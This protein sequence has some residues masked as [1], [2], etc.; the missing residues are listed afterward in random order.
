MLEQIV[1]FYQTDLERLADIWLK[2]GAKCFGL[3]ASDQPIIQWTKESKESSENTGSTNRLSFPINFM[4]RPLGEIFV[5]GISGDWV[6][7]LLES[8]GIYVLR[9]IDQER[10][11]ESLAQE[12]VNNQDQL[13]AVYDLLHS[14]RNMVSVTEIVEGIV[15]ATGQIFEVSTAFIQVTLPG[16]SQFVSAH[17]QPIEEIVSN[18]LIERT[19]SENDYWLFSS[20]VVED[21]ILSKYI[22]TAVTIPLNIQGES[23][24]VLGLID[25]KKGEF[26]S[27]D[28][29]LL[30]A[31]GKYVESEIENALMHEANVERVKAQTRLQTEM[32]L[33]HGVQMNLMPQTLPEFATLDLAAMAI[34]A[35]SVGGDFYDCLVQ[36]DDQFYFTLGDVSGKGMPAAL[37]MAMTRTTLRNTA[38][39]LPDSS[40]QIVLDRTTDALYDDFTEVEMFSTVFVGTY[41][42]NKEQLNYINAGHAPVIYRPVG[43]SAVILEPSGPPLGAWPENL[44]VEDCVPFGPGDVL[45]A[46]TDGLNEARNSEGDMFGYERLIELVDELADKT[47]SEIL[48]EVMA[49]VIEFSEGQ[50]QED[51]QTILILKRDASES[52]SGV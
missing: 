5:G 41:C 3:Q 26:E 50:E 45:L 19:L 22:D 2:A 38:R 28:I 52:S 30:R 15:Q 34:P 11:L 47:S 37:L 51:D 18:T 23:L 31:I 14:T 17:P 21:L 44:A 32:E 16:R 33:A 42:S 48:D 24:A 1:T 10:D 9:L 7:D 46:A 20:A 25:T 36:S 6:E 40:P 35:L 39:L 4:G 43:G 29:K 13:V 8:N 49:A 27:P 12:L